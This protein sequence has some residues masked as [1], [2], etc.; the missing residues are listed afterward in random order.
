MQ[1]DSE[2]KD[3][4]IGLI[5]GKYDKLEKLFSEKQ[6]CN[7]KKDI[8]IKNAQI[9]DLEMRI[10]ELEKNHQTVKKEQLKKIKEHENASKQK[11]WKSKRF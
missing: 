1:I 10:E 8:L 5:R 7:L 11:I 2:Q 9:N 3:S 6:I 4:E